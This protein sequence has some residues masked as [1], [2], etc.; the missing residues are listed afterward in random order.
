MRMSHWASS[1]TLRSRDIRCWGVRTA[2]F[3]RIAEAEPTMEVRGV[4]RSWDTAR[5]RLA[6]MA[7]RSVSA[8]SCSCRLIWE[9]RVLT[10]RDT[11]S[12]VRKVRGSPA[13]VKLKAQ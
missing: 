10:R 3:S 8:R 1:R 2:S 5:S 13:M 12:M 11:D 4:R 6:R 9:V 7:S